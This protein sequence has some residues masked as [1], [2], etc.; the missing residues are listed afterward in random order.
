[1]IVQALAEQQK[2][3]QLAQQQQGGA[4]QV[5]AAPGQAQAPAAG[6]A[7]AQVPQAAAVAGAA[8]VPST[9]IL[10]RKKPHTL[11]GHTDQAHGSC[12]C[13]SVSAKVGIQQEKVERYHTRLWGKLCIHELLLCCNTSPDGSVIFITSHLSRQCEFPKVKWT[14]HSDHND[15]LS[16]LQARFHR[17]TVTDKC[18]RG[19]VVLQPTAPT[20]HLPHFCSV[21][22]VTSISGKSPAR[23]KAGAALC[24]SSWTMAVLPRHIEQDTQLLE[25]VWF[26]KRGSNTQQ[27]TV[28]VNLFSSFT[29]WSYKKCRRGYNHPGW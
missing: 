7:Q 6:Q 2:A 29:G 10:V 4:P 15:P 3:Q 12:F 14:H 26:W 9:A 17:N 20:F 23:V 16:L 28:Y 11:T 22:S 19:R 13:E 24:S 27:N 5:Q 25:H 1:M 18:L 21:R 8:T